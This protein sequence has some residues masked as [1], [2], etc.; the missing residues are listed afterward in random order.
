M[1]LHNNNM[2]WLFSILV[3]VAL[4]TGGSFLLGNDNAVATDTIKFSQLSNS[5]IDMI[6]AVKSEMQT[7]KIQTN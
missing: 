3:T 6:Y 4:F 7:A 2:S 5:D 1:N